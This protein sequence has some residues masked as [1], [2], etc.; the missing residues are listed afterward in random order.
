MSDLDDP[1]LCC[2][3]AMRGY[4]RGVVTLFVPADCN[5][6]EFATVAAKYLGIDESIAP[7]CVAA[8]EASKT[9]LN[10]RMTLANRFPGDANV[11]ILDAAIDGWIVH[12]AKLRWSPTFKA[13]DSDA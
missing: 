9:V 4:L 11:M 1:V 3:H 13:G 6:L 12:R 7:S 5:T 2:L 8:V 10:N